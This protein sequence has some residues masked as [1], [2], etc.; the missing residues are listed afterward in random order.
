MHQNPFKLSPGAIIMAGALLAISDLSRASTEET[1]AFWLNS[2]KQVIQA[3]EKLKVNASTAKNVILFVGDGMGVSTITAARILEG[4]SKPD[5][6]G[7]EENAL[8]FETLPYL[9]L[10]KTYSINQQ[11]SDSAPT[12]TAMITGVKTNDG[13]LS[14]GKDVVRQEKNASVIDA[15]KVKT[16]LEQAEDKGL[17]TG[18][19]STARITH[20]TPAACYTIS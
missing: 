10:S 3:S 1:P 17:S 4:Q 12:M 15:H 6:R 16:L 11:T 18:I 13:E 19:V 8:S 2:G 20:A 7:G 9:A 5:N 14:V